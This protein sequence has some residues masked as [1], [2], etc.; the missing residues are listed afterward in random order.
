MLLERRAELE[1]RLKNSNVDIFCLQATW[2]AEDIK[3]IKI[4]GF[5][6]VGRLDG[7][8]GPKRGFGGVCVYARSSLAEIVVFDLHYKSRT[9]VVCAAY[10]HR[11]AADRK[12]VP[13][14]R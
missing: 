14:P 8:S 4:C 10:K 1:A 6:I 5:H 7:A 13:R 2:L 9:Y 11:G 12:P 3:A